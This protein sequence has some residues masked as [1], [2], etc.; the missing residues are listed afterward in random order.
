MTLS[1]GW[2]GAT[3][4]PRRAAAG[5][6]AA[7]AVV[8]GLW[9]GVPALASAAA[10]RTMAA[11]APATVKYYIVPAPGKGGT[12]TL[13]DIALRTLGNGSRYP[14]I[15]SLNKGRLEPGG[16]RMESPRTIRSGWILQLPA[17]AH[18][19]GVHVGPLPVVTAAT[20]PPS[21]PPVS[22]PASRPASAPAVAAAHGSS[23]SIAAAIG[24]MLLVILLAG[25]AVL[26][27]RRPWRPSASRAGKRRGPD[28]AGQAGDGA[29]SALAARVAARAGRRSGPPDGRAEDPAGG[30]AAGTGRRPAAQAGQPAAAGGDPWP[31]G[32]EHPGSAGSGRPDAMGSGPLPVRSG[33]QPGFPEADWPGQARGGRQGRGHPAGA[34]RGQPGRQG[35]GYPG[36]AGRGRR[37]DDGAGYPGAAGPDR[38]TRRSG[39]RD[40][41]ILGPSSLVPGQ[42][43]AT[44]P[45]YARGPEPDFGP[46]GPEHPSYPGAGHLD[47][48]RPEQAS[49][50]SSDPYSSMGPEHPSYPGAGHLDAVRPEQA[51]PFSSDPYGP[52]GPE[53]PGYPGAGPLDAAQ[54]AG[55][56]WRGADQSRGSRPLSQTAGSPS[57]PPARHRGGGGGGGGQPGPALAEMAHPSPAQLPTPSGRHAAR[58]VAERPQPGELVPWNADSIRLAERMLAD[59]DE[60]ATM[61]VTTAERTAAEISQSAAEQAAAALTA[62]E[63]EA[64]RVRENLAEMTAELGRVAASVMENLVAPAQPSAQPA[65]KPASRP[66]A[67]AAG[68]P[69]AQASAAGTALEVAASAP[70]ALATTAPPAARPRRDTTAQPATRPGVSP[71][72]NPKPKPAT[73]S[74]NRQVSAWRKAVAAMVALVAIG[75]GI[76]AAEIGRHGYAF[77]V[78]RNTGAGAGN[79][80]NLE[81]NQGPGRPDAPGAHHQAHGGT[82]GGPAT[83]KSK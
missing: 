39:S 65:R 33:A 23:L 4:G 29:P 12:E 18:G 6:L 47:A 35:P 38:G 13:Y 28:G 76:S 69:A 66:A 31:Y 41:G 77:F 27:V 64:A 63:Q 34:G 1:W 80:Q 2:H 82:P 40:P 21:A 24:G 43:A 50:F 68:P 60:Q 46:M 75:V 67:L 7:A 10:P 58:Q 62:A 56:S 70:G 9:A 45:M 59:A 79:P 14:E 8:A 57:W 25:L 36:A 72:R 15:F 30:R 42:A 54:T 73:T 48:V 49:P 74:K 53:H 26:L 37:D 52:R 16:A 3:G 61:I 71:R 32:P 51:T 17:S 44:G 22:A 83:K 81:E 19:P 20:S 5:G 78:F 11:A 55:P